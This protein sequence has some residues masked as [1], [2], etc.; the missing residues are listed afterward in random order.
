MN[1]IVHTRQSIQHIAPVEKHV[2]ISISN[3][4]SERPKIPMN[5]NWVATL[6]CTF[7]DVVHTGYNPKIITVF[8]RK[9]ANEI[10]DFWQAHLTAKS[11]YV[12]CDG[13][14][15][16]SPAVAAALQRLEI[17]EDDHWF[18]MKNPN[19]LVYRLILDEGYRRN[20]NTV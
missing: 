18:S 14:Q 13:G 6:P 12:H 19:R 5:A 17:G 8:T 10:L 7:H 2:I 16:R 4:A 11:L 3:H 15:C 20:L 1:Y 9:M